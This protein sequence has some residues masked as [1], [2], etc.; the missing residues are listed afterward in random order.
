MIGRQIIFEKHVKPIPFSQV[1]KGL[2]TRLEN[3]LLSDQ[4]FD[5][6]K[7]FIRADYSES[8]DLDD[9]AIQIINEWLE[10]V[11]SS[12]S[13]FIHVN[14]S[15]LMIG[16]DATTSVIRWLMLNLEQYASRR[17]WFV[18]MSPQIQDEQPN[19][20]RRRW[21]FVLAPNYNERIVEVPKEVYHVTSIYNVETILRRGLI[22]KSGQQKG[23]SHAAR[24]YA[25]RIY[26][27][28]NMREA[29]QLLIAFNED[30]FHASYMSGK[31]SQLDQIVLTIDTTKL[32]KGT[33]FYVDAEMGNLED[34][35]AMWT[36]SA[37]SAKAISVAPEF[38]SAFDEF[39]S[40]NE[41]I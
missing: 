28:G 21:N 4:V 29:E 10:S 5:K 12:S 18:L 25:P 30:D 31:S 22:P 9:V 26:V 33:K 3:L 35:H 20:S 36:Y 6:V 11:F 27:T 13:D 23:D 8:E 2:N 15:S 14:I 34:S 7:D 16:R 17:G 37:I 41:Y 40:A 32:N 24:N 19:S 38:Q 39:L 1:E